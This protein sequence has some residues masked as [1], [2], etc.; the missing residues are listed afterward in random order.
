MTDGAEPESIPT[1]KKLLRD[2]LRTARSTY[3]ANHRTELTEAAAKNAERLAWWAM[4]RGAGVAAAYASTP[5]E[6]TTDGLLDALKASSIRVLLPVMKPAG[7]MEWSPFSGVEGLVLNERGIREP[8]GPVYA[9][10]AIA[11]ADLL[12]VPAL[13][14]TRDGVRL[15]QGAGYYDRVLPHV[16]TDVPIIAMV[17]DTEVLDL[18]AIP[19]QEHD[20]RVT[21]ICTPLAGLRAVKAQPN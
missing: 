15:G 21:H 8:R 20:V 14:V 9:A 3:V 19:E 11:G 12:I 2:T 16:R 6:P 1:Q 5:E 10:Q 4:V 13:A 18:G 17:Y 7:L